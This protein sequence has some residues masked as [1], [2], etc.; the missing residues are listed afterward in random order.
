MQQFQFCGFRNER[1]YPLLVGTCHDCLPRSATPGTGRVG[2]CGWNCLPT[3]DDAPHLP[4]VRAIVEEILRCRPSVPL[5]VAHVATEDDWYEG[6]F[7][8]KGTMCIPN[9]WHCNRDRVVF[10]EDADE[11]RPERHIDERGELLS[12]PAKTIQA[13]H[14]SFGFGRR[15]CVGMHLANDTLFINI[16][17]IL[18]ATRL[19][20]V[21]DENGKEIPLDTDSFVDTG[22]T[23]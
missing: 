19:E 21:R 10:G 16:A 9:I 12:G 6:M 5:G 1:Y 23:V 14:A 7:I 4:Y 18:W 17:R 15:I 13:G 11:F 2:C 8:P 22:I 20:G 3:F